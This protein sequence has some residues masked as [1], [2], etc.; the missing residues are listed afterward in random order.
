MVLKPI[1]TARATTLPLK[2]ICQKHTIVLNGLSW[3]HLF[4]K[5][6]F[7]LKWI[8]WVMMCVRSVSYRIFLNG[9]EFG[10]IVPER[11]LKQ[12]DPLS[13]FLFILCAEALV[14]IMNTAEETGKITG[15]K[16]T[17][18]CPLVQHLLFVDDS[19]FLIR[20]ELSE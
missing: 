20:A 3:K 18:K 13:S 19:L 7:D 9:Q 12:G 14:H 17:R 10:H 2:P 16:L 8:D 5:M 15:M 4:D 6:G 11:G 1:R